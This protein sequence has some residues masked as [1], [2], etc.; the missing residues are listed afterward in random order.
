M[1]PRNAGHPAWCDVDQCTG[2]AG[3]LHYSRAINVPPPQTSRDAARFI[4]VVYGDGQT[5]PLLEML[6]APVNPATTSPVIE[7]EVG[8]L[9]R[10]HAALGAALHVISAGDPNVTALPEVSA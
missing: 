10:L 1:S 3:Q 2:T 6:A 4:L 5:R 9:R 7:F 8:Q